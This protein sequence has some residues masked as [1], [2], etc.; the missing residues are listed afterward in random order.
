GSNQ[1]YWTDS[2]WDGIADTRSYTSQPDNVKDF[3]RT[4]SNLVNTI[5]MEG[6]T[7]NASLRFSFTNNIAN[8]IMPEAGL[9]RNNFNLRAFAKPTDFF[10][11]DAKVT[12]FVQDSKYRIFQGT[13]GIMAYLYTIPR[14]PIFRNHDVGTCT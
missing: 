13:E 8:S 11:V 7:Q 12:Y 9:T 2:K 3:F 4:G 5:A 1:L 10:S 14:K 6:G